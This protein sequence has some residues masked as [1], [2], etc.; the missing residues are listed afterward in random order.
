MNLGKVLSFLVPLISSDVK[1]DN[2]QPTLEGCCSSCK[3]L[4]YSIRNITSAINVFAIFVRIGV[5]CF[6][7]LVGLVI[8]FFLPSFLPS[9]LSF[10]FSFFLSFFIFMAAPTAYGSS[11]AIGQIGATAAGLCHSLENTRSEPQLAAGP[12]P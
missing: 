7:L 9:F 1:W 8:S 5:F 10:S 3:L 12:D 4:N 2:N 6:G 11:Q